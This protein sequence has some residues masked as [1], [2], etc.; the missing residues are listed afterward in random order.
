MANA[1]FRALFA[2]TADNH[3]QPNAWSRRPEL[4]N[5]A[6]VSFRQIADYCCQHRLPLVLGGDT[7]DKARP[8][9]YSVRFFAQQAAAV[10]AASG[11]V[12][13]VQGDHDYHFL[14]PWATVTGVAVPLHE[15]LQRVDQFDLYG[16][17]WQSRDRLPAALA[18]INPSTDI[19]IAHQAWE[20]LQG[21]GQVEGSL[22]TV[23]YANIVLTGDYHVATSGSVHGEDGRLIRYWSPGSTC[24][25][26]IDE[27]HEKSFLV[28]GI[29][30]GDFEVR[31]VPLL[32]R[33]KYELE[34]ETEHAL[35]R[36]LASGALDELIN[37]DHLA[38]LPEEIRRPLLRVTFNDLIPDALQRIES[39]A[40]SRFHLFPNPRRMVEEI[41]IDIESAPDGGFDTLL[42]AC[43]RLSETDGIFDLTARMLRA[44]DKQS[45]LE[46]IY[47]EHCQQFQTIG[48]GGEASE[49]GGMG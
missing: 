17:D 1:G 14:A 16:I 48:P 37:Q 2:F 38:T 40:A 5:D 20:E 43:R 22:R 9:P 24:M 32:T 28:C 12:S 7:F 8:D 15:M 6:Y 49:R 41:G 11:V 27:D 31:T 21:I 19:L 30:N 18:T 46:Q 23:P 47:R 36:D 33:P 3:L 42:D 39:A 4:R 35:D 29:E 45:E 25:Q 13:F 10:V 26:S 34:Y 44:E